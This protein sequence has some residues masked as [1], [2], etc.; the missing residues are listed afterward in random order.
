MLPSLLYRLRTLF[1][2]PSMEAELDAELRAHIEQQ[3]EKYV[4]SG[5]SP[6]EA[7]RR[8]R[9]EL[10]GIEQV[11]EDVRDSWGVRIFSELAQDL[12][13]GLR[14]LRQNPGF[15]AVAVLTLA[16][17]IGATTAIFSVIQGV[18]LAPL[19]YT[20]PDRLVMV[21]ETAPDGKL[22]IASYM[23]FKD[24]QRA[25]LP[26]ERLA[27]VSW[28]GFDLTGP[29]TPERIEGQQVSSDFFRS[30]GIK[31]VIGR[32]FTSQDDVP[33]SAPVVIISNRLWRERFSGKGVL[34][35]IV[36]L[37]GVDRTVIGVMPAGFLI[38]GHADV[39]L[40]LG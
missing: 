33:G 3:A 11:K 30:L 6:D 32:D 25:A 23:D 10:G 7:A 36:T 28:R 14:Q 2:R 9:L 31:P 39:F 4:R 27:A 8:A 19:P 1:R 37:D 29:G 5:L 26:F 22:H 18:L 12:S 15:T 34:G 16:L 17:G 38:W 21:W 35:K 20:H 24:W 13:Y 40:P